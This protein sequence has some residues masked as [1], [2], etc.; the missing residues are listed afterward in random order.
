MKNNNNHNTTCCPLPIKVS[1]TTSQLLAV[2]P[3]TSQN[4]IL[5]TI[6]HTYMIKHIIN[7]IN[8]LPLQDIFNKISFRLVMRNM[9]NLMK[10]IEKHIT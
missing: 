4:S 8:D 9:Y 5:Y 2:I 1:T 3:L 10:Q 6:A 7:M